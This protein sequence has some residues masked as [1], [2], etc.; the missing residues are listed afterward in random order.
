MR[1]E[2]LEKIVAAKDPARPVVLVR[3]LSG[4]L[5]LLVDGGV[6]G[7]VEAASE[8]VIREAREAL[9]R[10]GAYVTEIGG[11]RYLIQTLSSPPRL[12]VVGAVHIAQKLI[13]MARIVGLDVVLIDPRPAFASASRFPG[14]EV[15]AEWPREAMSRLGLNARTAVVTLSHDAKIDEPAL[16]AALESEAFYIGAL[17]SR[18]N[19][20]K[21]LERLAALGFDAKAL[22]RIAA[23]IG[24]PLGGRSPAE[25]AVAILA[26]V[27]QSRYRRSSS[28]AGRERA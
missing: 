11:E 19:H 3:G 8:E 22:G 9:G 25:I 15:I 2:L 4:S 5:T 18:K 21:R 13:P 10:D 12:V 26:E 7:D 28:A 1:H 23:P 16:Q 14:V 27:I 17:G 24:L 6:Q 20:A